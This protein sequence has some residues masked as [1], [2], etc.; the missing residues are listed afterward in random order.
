MNPLRW[1][2]LLMLSFMRMPWEGGVPPRV[3]R[4]PAAVAPRC[5]GPREAA[6]IRRAS[7]HPWDAIARVQGVEQDATE[8]GAHARPRW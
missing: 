1:Q 4:R 8:D 7:L 5:L 3:A 6:A 2:P